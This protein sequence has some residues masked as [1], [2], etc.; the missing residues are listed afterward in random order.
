HFK[1]IPIHFPIY[2]QST[3]HSITPPQFIL[4]TTLQHPKTK[5]NSSHNINQK[6]PLIPSSTPPDYHQTLNNNFK[7]FNHNFQSYFSNFTQPLPNLKF[8]N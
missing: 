7:H 1:H 2:K 4:R 6:P 5:I 3:Q 8:L